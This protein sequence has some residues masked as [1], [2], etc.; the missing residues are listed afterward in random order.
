MITDVVIPALNEE[1][2]LPLVLAG[3]RDARIRTV[4][5]G[6]NGSTDRTAEVARAAGAVV[7]AAPR[8]GYGSACLAA[9]AEVRRNPPDTVLFIDGDFSDFPD[10]AGLLLDAIEQGADLVIGS[11]NLGG[12]EKGALMP[13]ARFGNWLSTRLIRGLWGVAFTDLGPFR[14]VRWEALERLE[15]VDPDFGWTVEMQ[16]RAASRGLVCREVGVRYR[17]RI[18]QSKVSG[19]VKGSYR[20]GKKI[21]YVI[22]REK[23]SEML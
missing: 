3:L 11:R 4:Y 21:L 14:A 15:M 12:A 9:L 10:E 8:R 1:A 16:V 7:V 23:V 6:D 18:G 2:S 5:V 17:A 19:T 13:V 20:A 22:A